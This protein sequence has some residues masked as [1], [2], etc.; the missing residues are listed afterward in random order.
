MPLTSVTRFPGG[1]TNLNVGDVMADLKMQHPGLYTDY[2]NDFITLIS[3]DWTSAGTGTAAALVANADGGVLS[4]V[5]ATAAE[6]DFTFN[7]KAVTPALTRDMYFSALVQ[8][9]GTDATAAALLV[10]MTVAD[11]TPIATPPTDG[12]YIRKAAASTQ[13]VAVLRIGG[14]DVST[15]NMGQWALN[16][17]SEMGFVYTAANGILNA[18][19]GGGQYRL[20]TNPAAFPAA[21]LGPNF[22]IGPGASGAAQTLQIDH[23]MFGK[24]KR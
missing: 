16:T 11:A 4:I 20:A 15:V 10:G 18:F 14:V 21:G 13:V 5:S 1:S 6:E 12:I 8:Q 22:S 7:N 9:T 23:V 17:W 3:A 19:M 2:D 24:G